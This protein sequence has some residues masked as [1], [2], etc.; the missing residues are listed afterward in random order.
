MT[1]PQTV[2]R[3]T[4][5]H[6][7]AILI[8]F[9]GIVIAVN[10]YMARQAVGTFGGVVVDNSYVASQN[11]NRWLGEAER[12]LR[13]GWTPHVTLDQRRRIMLTATR[14]GAALPSLSATGMALHPLG[15]AAPIRL[16]FLTTGKGSLLSR[17]SL[18]P[19]RWKVQL[20]LRSN[21]SQFKLS[22]AVQ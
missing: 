18:P 21:A 9:F 11:Y 22:E 17:Q 13:L 1:Q 10:L 2:R 20:T 15:R 14:N 4:G 5:W 7:T 3:F 19:G 6:M 12:Q 8:G 16:S